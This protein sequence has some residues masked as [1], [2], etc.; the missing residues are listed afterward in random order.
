MLKK[1]TAIL[2]TGSLIIASAVVGGAA[3][4]QGADQQRGSGW[5]QGR[6]AFAPFERGMM[7]GARLGQ[8]VS[9]KVTA[10]NGMSITMESV[11][12]KETKTYSVDAGKA[13]F[14]KIG[15]PA[16]VGLSSGAGLVRPSPASIA[17]TD[18][19]IGDTV[20]VRGTVNGNSIVATSVTVMPGMGYGRGPENGFTNNAI[21]GT[22]Q[23]VN[24][25]MLTVVVDRFPMGRR[26]ADADGTAE[27]TQVTYVVDAS[28]ATVKKV[29]HS[30]DP[31]AKPTETAIAVS[32]IAVGDK[33]RVEGT[34]DGTNVKADSIIDGVLMRG[35]A[36]AAPSLEKAFANN[37]QAN[38]LK[39]E[40]EAAKPGLWTK[41]ISFFSGL[42]GRHR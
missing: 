24:G 4:A 7:P 37:A 5:G 41:I 30:S 25:S 16:P 17:I 9:G 33:L 13:T 12:G 15:T 42:F 40:I 38:S 1:R 27:K 20:A 31:Q 39:A 36:A 34:I 26:D 29:V 28:S 2:A 21:S 8:G 6:A 18:I 14:S 19:T 32:D 22:V 23:A 11:F 10:I 3:H 35:P